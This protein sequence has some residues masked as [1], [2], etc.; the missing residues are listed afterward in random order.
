MGFPERRVSGQEDLIGG[1][2]SAMHAY[3]SALTC[4]KLR[5]PGPSKW[6]VRI[7]ALLFC[8][9]WLGGLVASDQCAFNASVT[10]ASKVWVLVDHGRVDLGQTRYR[11]GR[12]VP[13]GQVT[14]AWRRSLS[15]PQ[16]TTA[17]RLPEFSFTV[18]GPLRVWR[19][20][21]ADSGWIPRTYCREGIDQSGGNA[22]LSRD[23]AVT[24]PAWLS[25]TIASVGI[26]SCSNLWL[27]ATPSQWPFGLYRR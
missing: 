27:R 24:F 7:L 18:L 14:P 21:G 13:L 10:S 9:A 16:S 2:G 17:F 3:A 8:V 15:R 11:F 26:A 12:A 25:V 5:L 22:V 20:L 6:I 23:D 4:R 19:P 1:D